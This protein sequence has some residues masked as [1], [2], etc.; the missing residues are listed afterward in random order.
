MHSEHGAPGKTECRTQGHHSERGDA[1]KGRQLLLSALA[2][3]SI[4]V[5]LKNS[6][7]KPPTPGDV[8]K[9]GSCPSR[10]IFSISL[11]KHA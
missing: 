6:F 3:N 9:G 8:D 4:K 5:Q 10:T 7:G 1:P 2:F 11:E